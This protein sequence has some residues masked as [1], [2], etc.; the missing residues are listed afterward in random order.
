[1]RKVLYPLYRHRFY[2]VRLLRETGKQLRTINVKNRK[3]QQKRT[4]NNK[5]KRS[6]LNLVVSH[7]NQTSRPDSNIGYEISIR[8]IIIKRKQ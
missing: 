3:Q 1:M 4:N 6:E 2:T 8:V 7:R 5:K